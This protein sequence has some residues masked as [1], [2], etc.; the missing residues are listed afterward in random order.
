MNKKLEITQEKFDRLLFWLDEDK[1]AAARKYHSIHRRL[2]QIFLA[3]DVYPAEEFADKAMDIGVQ[4]IEHLIEEYEGNKAL[5]FYGVAN[6]LVYEFLRAQ[7]EESLSDNLVSDHAS[8]QFHPEPE[9]LGEENAENQNIYYI[10]LKQ[11]LKAQPTGSR[12]LLVKYFQYK[13]QKKSIYHKKI[14][15][16]LGISVNLLR[17]KVYR[18]KKSVEEC[19]KNRFLDKNV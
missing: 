9:S 10:Y 3:R 6:N 1:D 16:K 18:I 2:V 17:T 5:F 7:K 19:V 11:C 4:K 12:N 13:K 15:K 8:L 14:A